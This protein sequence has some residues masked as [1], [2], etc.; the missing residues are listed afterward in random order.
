MHKANFVADPEINLIAFLT[1]IMMET[2]FK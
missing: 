2:S 1:E